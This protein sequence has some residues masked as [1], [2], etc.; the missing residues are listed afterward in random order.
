MNIAVNAT[1][2][3]RSAVEELTR[4]W[5]QVSAK[6]HYEGLLLDDDDAMNQ[7]LQAADEELEEIEEQIVDLVVARQVKDIDDAQLILGLGIQLHR[8][9]LHERAAA[10]TAA[11]HR[12]LNSVRNTAEKRAA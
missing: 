10:L 9:E 11:A 1:T 2:R 8:D 3:T 7:L 4:R 12:S 6:A 5:R